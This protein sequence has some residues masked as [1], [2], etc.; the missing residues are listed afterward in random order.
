MPFIIGAD[1]GTTNVKSVAFDLYGNILA[2]HSVGY[3]IYYP[4]DDW[5][6]QDPEEMLRATI[7]SISTVYEMCKKHGE[8]KGIT[9]SS[10]M[11]S[12]I[13]LDEQG[14][15]LTRSI[16]WADNRSAD[17][18]DALRHSSDGR[19]L[20]HRNGTPIHAMT[21]ACKLLWLRQH[22]PDLFA[23]AAMYVGIKEYVLYKLTGKY[24]SDYSLASATGLFNIRNLRWDNWTL[25]FLGLDEAQLPQ[26]VSPFHI[27][28]LPAVNRLGLP[29]GTPL[30]MGASD[31]CLANLGSGAM[32]PDS[33]AVTI[34]TSGAARVISRSAYTDE[35]MRTFCYLLDGKTYVVGGATNNGGVIFQWLKDNLFAEWGYDTLFE[36]ATRIAPGAD[37]LL[38]MP[39]LLG[40][41]AP[42]W[43]SA[44]RGG[45]MGL[46]IKHTKS[47]LARAVM[48]GILLNLY[49]IGKVLMEDRSITSIYAN[50]GFARSP[51]WVQMLAD[52]FGI[53]VRLNDTVDTGSVGA[54]MVGLKALGIINDYAEVPLF[55]PVGQV[56]EPDAA[57]HGAYAGVSDH[58]N[59]IAQLMLAQVQKE[60]ATSV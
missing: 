28:E 39:Y 48:E 38:F 6:E 35:Q 49:S 8:L 2:Q 15:P 5:S 27:E 55:T 34:G 33:M 20:Y 54:A 41:R 12:L 23:R 9:F 56:V 40:E 17:L 60:K 14:Q 4:Q 3:P 10:A 30:I 36:S 11:H 7:Q 44:V 18:A 43:N 21:P 51:I 45:F 24:L 58:F 53:P 1:I 19:L 13:A 31:G 57:A 52:V 22:Q 25:N 16:I 26:A 29:A 46:D 32:T 59:Q 37:G 42:L 50:G 47:H